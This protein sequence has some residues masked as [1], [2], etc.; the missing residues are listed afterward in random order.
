MP[1]GDRC[2]EILDRA[3]QRTGAA[4]SPLD[5][6]IKPSD[7]VE[8]ARETLLRLHSLALPERERRFCMLDL[9][10]ERGKTLLGPGMGGFDAAQ[11][12]TAFIDAA[13]KPSQS[14]IQRG[15]AAVFQTGTWRRGR[16]TGRALAAHPV[17]IRLERRKARFQIATTLLRTQQRLTGL[18]KTRLDRGQFLPRSRERGLFRPTLGAYGCDISALLLSATLD[19]G[20]A[21]MRF[22][23]HPAGLVELVLAGRDHILRHALALD[24]AIARI[25]GEAPACR[26]QGGED[27]RHGAPSPEAVTGMPVLHGPPRLDLSHPA[28]R[29]ACRSES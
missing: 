27:Q 17:D 5:Q 26:G 2:G 15:R 12:I 13:I 11:C 25:E 14:G 21:C 7:V 8:K 18:F 9:L 4:V 20:E 3:R 29:F 19:L 28:M 23:L 1:F 16:N 10:R 6:R 22:S 24:R